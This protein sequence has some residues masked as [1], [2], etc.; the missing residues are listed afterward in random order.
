MVINNDAIA[1]FPALMEL[2]DPY[3][4]RGAIVPL[5]ITDLNYTLY[6]YLLYSEA[7]E[8][9]PVEQDLIQ[10]ISSLFAELTGR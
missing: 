10:I 8:K 7:I 2:G 5:D 4:G 9:A 3:I 1:I 6:Y